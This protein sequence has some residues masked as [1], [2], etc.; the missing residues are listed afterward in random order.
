MVHRAAGDRQEFAAFVI[1]DQELGVVA[2]SAGLCDHHAPGPGNLSGVR[3]HV[4]NM[5]TAPGHRGRGYARACLEA[6]LAWFRDETQ[7][8]LI[9]LNASRDGIALYQSLGFG[10]PGHPQLRL[11]RPAPEH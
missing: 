2:C 9:N 8:S 10:P 5:S 11:A 6:L 7:A 4:F 3:G 1:D